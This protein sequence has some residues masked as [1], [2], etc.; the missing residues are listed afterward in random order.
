VSD[1]ITNQ[2]LLDNLG[3]AILLFSNDNK[4]AQHNTMAGTVL[5]ADLNVI[6]ER[7]W[8]AAVE[9]FNANI[10]SDD[11]NALDNVRKRALASQRPIRFHTTRNGEY[12]PGWASAVTATDGSV[13]TLITLDNVDW[14]LVNSV[15]ERFNREMREAVDSTIGHINLINKTLYKKDDDEATAKIARR[16]GGFSKLIAMHMKRTQRL[17]TMVERL[18]VIRTGKIRPN[19]QESR[20]KIKLDD[21]L[22]DFMESLSEM[23]L[24]DPETEAHDYR[25]RIKLN[26][27]E[28]IVLNASPRYLTYTLQELLRNAIMYSL[29]GTPI[30]INASF[31][32]TVAQIDVVDEGH[33]IRE[34]DYKR[35]FTPFERGSQPQIISE[36][37]Y[38]LALHLCSNEINAMN[39]KLWFTS[40]ENISTTFSMM[41]PLYQDASSSSMNQ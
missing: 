9:L 28:G 26:L 17:M 24:L 14:G 27:Q 7:G 29:R 23:E 11:D 21:F 3:H 25:S 8:V 32:N 20:T 4:L 15:L 2:V 41:L 22:E 12:V 10:K 18:E 30:T 33:G 34:K 36:F 40:T 37:G 6:R 39:G 5:G 16:L 35:V 38:G 31:R 13:Y 19:A 1:N